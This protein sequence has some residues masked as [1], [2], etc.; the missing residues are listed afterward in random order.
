M[1][2][3]CA[4]I[5]A[6]AWT[7]RY[8]FLSCCSFKVGYVLWYELLHGL[9]RVRGASELQ[10]SA[11]AK[12]VRSRGQRIT[13]ETSNLSNVCPNNQC[14]PNGENSPVS[15]SSVRKQQRYRRG[16][17]VEA[18]LLFLIRRCAEKVSQNENDRVS[19]ASARAHIG[20]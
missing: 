15:L 18:F 16:V 10:A 9:G 12:I 19:L 6:G 7:Q 3:S 17:H 1:H 14:R 20:G 11:H 8:E 4:R 13:A 5:D 2:Y